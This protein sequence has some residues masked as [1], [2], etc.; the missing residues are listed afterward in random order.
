MNQ[1]IEPQRTV[2][3]TRHCVMSLVAAMSRVLEAGLAGKAGTLGQAHAALSQ[4]LRTSGVNDRFPVAIRPVNLLWLCEF[5]R[6]Q[7]G[8]EVVEE[9]RAT[10]PRTREAGE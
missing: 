6:G 8:A 9:L 2:T 7:V 10:V 4:A 5:A 3:L 1:P